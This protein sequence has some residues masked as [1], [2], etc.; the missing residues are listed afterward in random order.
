[1][2]RISISEL[3]TLRWSFFQDAVRCASLGFESIGV[4]RPK[5]ADFNIDEGADL[6]F[7]MKMGVSSLHWAGGFTGSEGPSFI[8][9]IDDAIDAIQLASRLNAGCLIIH[10]GARNGHTLTHANRLLR[11]ALSTLVPVAKDF[12]VQLAIEPIPGRQP[13]EWTFL[14]RLEDSLD[15][16]SEFE[17]RNIGLV[18][19]LYH[20][21]LNPDAFEKLPE[22]INRVALIQLADRK[23]SS[24][25]PELRQQLGTGNVPLKNWLRKF[26]ELGYR[27]NYEVELFGPAV[28]G[29]NSESAD[30]FQML[31]ATT[32]YLERS[33]I[34]ELLALPAIDQSVEQKSSHKS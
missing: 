11:C 32:K 19:D 14:E 1:M 7:E 29:S 13:S 16:I 20:V 34:Q 31:E 25:G 24:E 30:Y 8:E 4:W 27:G 12:D 21:G 5:I 9:A 15:L 28:V 6:L 26:Q 23:S 18:L 2:Q 3:S 22:F 10:P 17:F 33:S